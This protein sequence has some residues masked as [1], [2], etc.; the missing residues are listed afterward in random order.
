MDIDGFFLERA[1]LTQKSERLYKLYKI[2][3]EKTMMTSEV[4]KKN[5]S[6]NKNG[7]RWHYLYGHTVLFHFLWKK[8][9][10]NW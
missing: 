9:E 6:Y 1:Y 8:N 10:L 5:G 7:C 4:T 3:K 2:F